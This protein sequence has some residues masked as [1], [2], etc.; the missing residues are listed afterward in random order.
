VNDSRGFYTSRVFSTWS[1]EGIKMLLEGQHPHAI[2]MAGL[3]AG[4]PVGPLAVMDEISLGLADHIRKQT[5]EDFQAAGQT[6]T[7][8]AAA[9]RGDHSAPVIDKMLSLKRPGRAG[10]GGFYEYTEK[11][12]HL[13][14]ELTSIFMNG[15]PQLPQQEMIDRIIYI[16]AVET[17]RC[18]EEGILRNTAD[19][20]L[21]A[22]FGWG[23]APQHGGPLQFINGCGLQKFVDRAN[24]LGTAYGERFAPPQLL[25]DMAARGETF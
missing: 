6:D 12:K 25:V 13:W 23:F 2:E 3:Q 4:M 20:N 9:Q 19:A 5:I 24:E 8:L 1:N 10:G 11:G 16:Q 22:I 14:P 17:A 21:G 15:Q 7:A 18:M